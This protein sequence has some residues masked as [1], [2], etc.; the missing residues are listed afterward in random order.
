MPGPLARPHRTRGFSLIELIITVSVVAVLASVATPSMTSLM[1][2]H[3]VQ[4]ASSDLFATLLKA[5]G[6]A[7]MLNSDVRVLPVG[8]DWAAGWQV[9]D[10]SNAGKY[11]DVHEPLGAVVVAMSGA[12][13]VSYQFNGR[14]RADAGVKFSLTASNARYATSA[15]ISVDP[16]GRPYVEDKPCAG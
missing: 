16:S 9:P 4:D 7:I 11:L 15:C 1:M 14:I 10:P 12:S 8:G 3:R 5:R 13:T 6:E 2:R